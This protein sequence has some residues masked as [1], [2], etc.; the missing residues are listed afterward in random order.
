MKLFAALTLSTIATLSAQAEGFKCVATDYPLTIKAH[1]SESTHGEYVVVL[2]NSDIQYGRKTIAVVRR[3]FLND[4]V[5]DATV[6]WR[7]LES[8]RKGELLGPTKIGNVKSFQIDLGNEEM[9]IQQ[10]N[11]GEVTLNLACEEA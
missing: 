1:A 6:D 2:S 7:F 8:N 10:R 4:S 5:L 11:G 3:A 9:T